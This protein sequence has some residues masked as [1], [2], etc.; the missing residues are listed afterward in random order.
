MTEPWPPRPIAERTLVWDDG[1]DRHDVVLRIWPP[2]EWDDADHGRTF[3]CDFEIDGPPQPFRT[4]APGMDALGS[5][6]TALSWLHNILARDREKLSYL[7]EHGE[8]GIPMLVQSPYGAADTRRLERML[9]VDLERI[10]ALFDELRSRRMAEHAEEYDIPPLAA[11]DGRPLDELFT[12]VLD[13]A[14]SA[15]AAESDDDD[16]RAGVFHH[17]LHKIHSSIQEHP[18]RER[19]LGPL[20][21]SEDPLVAYWAARLTMGTNYS[22]AKATFRRLL[23]AG[24]VDADDTFVKTALYTRP[25]DTRPKPWD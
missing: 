20:R 10:N 18:D 21:T 25:I 23:D 8:H 11:L 3:Y 2:V 12:L 1:E 7:D 22:D 9:D 15:S 19:V 24:A 6:L 13:E 14:R 4:S 17:R 16:D 5:I